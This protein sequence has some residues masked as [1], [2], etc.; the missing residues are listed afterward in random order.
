MV[1]IVL[2]TYNGEKYLKEQLNSLVNQTLKPDEIVFVDDGSKDS[3]LTLVHQFVEE[4]PE[5]SCKVLLN[6]E[7]LGPARTFARG[8][9]NT[10]GDI[11]FFSDQDDIWYEFKLEQ[12]VQIFEQMPEVQVLCT[13]YDIYDD[14]NQTIIPKEYQSEMV[15]PI[16]LHEVLYEN[17]SPGCTTAL[18]ST[19][20]DEAKKINEKMYVHDWFYTILA[21]NQ[22]GLFFY[23]KSLIKYRVHQSNTVGMNI[24]FL[25]KLKKQR[26]LK[27]EKQQIKLLNEVVIQNILTKSLD[28]QYAEDLIK[29]RTNR[30]NYIE[31]N[32]SL[33]GYIRKQKKYEDF[34]FKSVIRDVLIKSPL[35][36]K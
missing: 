20:K 11:I 33:V 4:H 26:Y 14:K 8:V 31:G 27:D 18:R 9:M 22:N 30:L 34:N 12:M 15:K 2:A 10:S 32:L 6:E 5:I 7:N 16:S 3:T 24:S 13:A 36:S 28:R 17:V 1:S 35:E 23:D 19:L 29:K 21:A 25:Q